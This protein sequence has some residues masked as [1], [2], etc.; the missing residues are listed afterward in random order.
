MKNKII[1]AVPYFPSDIDHS[2]T[3]E[4]AEQTLKKF[5]ENRHKIIEYMR[6]ILLKEFDNDK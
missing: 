1:R 2:V 4:Q 5:K 3:K 6:N